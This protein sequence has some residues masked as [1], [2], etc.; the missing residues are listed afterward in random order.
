MAIIARISRRFLTQECNRKGSLFPGHQC[1]CA[2]LLP[3]E[4]PLWLAGT[5]YLYT[6]HVASWGYRLAKSSKTTE[7]ISAILKSLQFLFL[8]GSRGSKIRPQPLV[9][10]TTG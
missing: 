3:L 9:M 7:T 2:S 5:E 10:C 6:T 4:W 1:F 8:R